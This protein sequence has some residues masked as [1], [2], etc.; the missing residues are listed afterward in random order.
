KLIPVSLLV[1][2][3]MIIFAAAITIGVFGKPKWSQIKRNTSATDMGV[4]PSQNMLT[5]APSGACEGAQVETNVSKQ[6]QKPAEHA[7][8]KEVKD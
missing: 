7:A 2:V 5:E 1:P 4:S 3:F 6:P 8:T